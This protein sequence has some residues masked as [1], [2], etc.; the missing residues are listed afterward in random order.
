MLRFEHWKQVS[1]FS[2]CIGALALSGCTSESE[3]MP[4]TGTDEIQSLD[5]WHALADAFGRETAS[6]MQEAGYDTTFDPESGTIGGTGTADTAEAQDAALAEC[7]ADLEAEL[8]EV[9]LEE[10]LPQA[11]RE[12]NYNLLTDRYNCLID[13]GVPLKEPIPSLQNYLSDPTALSPEFQLGVEDVQVYLNELV[14][15]CPADRLSI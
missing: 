14:E 3:S 7:R 15:V 11:V 13:A 1:V 2:L 12:E 9:P 6:C 4:E 10:D 8:G 5:D